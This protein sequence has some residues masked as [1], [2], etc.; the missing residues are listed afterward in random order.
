MKASGNKANASVKPENAEA[1]PKVRIVEPGKDVKKNE[2]D[3]E[4]DDDDDDDEESDEE[5]EEEDEVYSAIAPPP[6][7]FGSLSMFEQGNV[8]YGF[9]E[10]AS[11]FYLGLIST[12]V[13]KGTTPRQCSY[14]GCKFR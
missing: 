1:K 8:P 9:S 11:Y 6:L 3:D 5:A 13:S 10:V 7:F 2:D 12:S 14:C 4:T